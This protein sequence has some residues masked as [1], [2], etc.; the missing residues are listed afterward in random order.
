MP[1]RVAE[2]E[3][4]TAGLA[5]AMGDRGAEAEEASSARPCKCY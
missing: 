2:M 4:W 1:L 5:E 3:A